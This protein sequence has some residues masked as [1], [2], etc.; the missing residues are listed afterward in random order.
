MLDTQTIILLQPLKQTNFNLFL[1]LTSQYDLMKFTSLHLKHD[2][3]H[4]PYKRF[5]ISIKANFLLTSIL[6]IWSKTYYLL[7]AYSLKHS[8]NPRRN[9][10]AYPYAQKCIIL[11]QKSNMPNKK[12][13]LLNLARKLRHFGGLLYR[14]L[15]SLKHL[16]LKAKLF[17]KDIEKNILE[18]HSRL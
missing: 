14:R 2:S 8:M 7:L 13:I 1:R 17:Y 15:C 11:M 10:Q 16:H 9:L 3:S 5:K 18:I 12:L 6:N 4:K